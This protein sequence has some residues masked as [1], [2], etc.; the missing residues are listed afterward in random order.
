M[1]MNLNDYIVLQR[2]HTWAQEDWIVPLAKAIEG[3]TASQAA[4]IP[5]VGG[6]T[7]WQMVNHMNYYNRRMLNRIGDTA[8]LAPTTITNEET[9]GAAG[10]AEDEA[11]WQHT[12]ALTTKISLS[13]EETLASMNE[14]QLHVPYFTPTKTTTLAELIVPWLIHDA[15]HIGQIVL[16]R[17]QQGSWPTPS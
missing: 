11:A 6:L 10:N 16:L 17:K 8:P 14:E 2:Q 3:L 5:T 15:Y 4:W 9:F 13:L 7:I 1:S 12:V